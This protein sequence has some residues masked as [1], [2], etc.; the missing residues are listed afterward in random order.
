M[1]SPLN[2]RSQSLEDRIMSTTLRAHDLTGNP[3]DRASWR[4]EVAGAGPT[5]G[6]SESISPMGYRFCEAEG[7]EPTEA[8][9]Y[10]VE[11]LSPGEESTESA[12]PPA[13]LGGRRSRTVQLKGAAGS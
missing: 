8:G 12:P 4:H 7:G 9:C 11:I 13:T 2:S 1:S 3:A 10:R 5:T 6:P